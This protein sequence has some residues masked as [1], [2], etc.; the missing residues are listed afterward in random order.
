LATIFTNR[1]MQNSNSSFNEVNRKLDAVVYALAHKFNDV[2]VNELTNR[3]DL[4]FRA[5][6]PSDD[7]VLVKT[8]VDTWDDPASNPFED[9][10]DFALDFEETDEYFY[11]ATRL[12][13]PPKTWKDLTS[14]ATQVDF[15][16]V[17]DPTTG[18]RV[19]QVDDVMIEKV[20]P[21]SGLPDGNAIMLAD[22]P[23]VPQALD[24]WDEVDTRFTRS[25]LLHV[26]R[27][28][29]EKTLNTWFGFHRTFAIANRN[30]KA[31]GVFFG[32]RRS[33]AL[34]PSTLRE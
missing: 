13:V 12:M 21:L 2:Y 29:D 33:Y 9:I 3:F 10:R 16:W 25:G 24:V 31:V 22:G 1:A 27:V 30:P 7:Q 4:S 20:P 32:L 17:K 23:G 8:V 6:L 11:P 14:Y 18:Q 19:F 15:D 5:T 26:Q 34:V 28:F